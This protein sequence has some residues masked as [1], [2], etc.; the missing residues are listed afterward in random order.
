LSMAKE[1]V[2]A[3]DSCIALLAADKLPKQVM[4]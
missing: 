4:R 2:L 1:S 3:A